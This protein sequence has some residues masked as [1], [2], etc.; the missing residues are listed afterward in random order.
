[1][2]FGAGLAGAG[3]GGYG[4]LHSLIR[5]LPTVLRP[6]GMFAYRDV[7]AVKA[8]SLHDRALQTY[9]GRSWVRFLRMFVPQY[10]QD[11]THP[12]HSSADLVVFRQDSRVVPTE[13]LDEK[14][15]VFAS[16]PVGFFREAQRHYITLR[17]HVWRSG[18]L[19]FWPC[20][21]GP[22]SADW[23]DA[24]HGHKRVHY[25]LTDTD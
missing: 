2:V 21:E 4:G 19:G 23:I 12:Y 20:L 1:M 8:A 9:T 7:Y 16:A 14:T 5:T 25:S 22:L 17:D 24:K 3:G 15:S 13:R 18:V 6:G 10:L 11:G